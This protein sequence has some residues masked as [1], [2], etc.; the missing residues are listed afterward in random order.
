MRV[1]LVRKLA[2]RIDGVDLSRRS[3]G[4]TFRVP[5]LQARLLIAEH[6]AVPVERPSKRPARHFKPSVSREVQ[7]TTTRK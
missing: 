7:S 6:W 5:P 1:Q 4:D 3:V 2:E